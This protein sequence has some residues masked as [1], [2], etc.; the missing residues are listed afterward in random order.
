MNA[1][2]GIRDFL[3]QKDSNLDAHVPESYR[4]TR[5]QKKENLHLAMLEGDFGISSA[6]RCMKP[7][8]TNLESPVVSQM[9]ADC[10]TNCTAKALETLAHFRL[11]KA[12][13]EK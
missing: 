10:M 13:H 3:V 5:T 6:A 9:E 12:M 7:C 2:I 1:N 8:F 11:N 4:M